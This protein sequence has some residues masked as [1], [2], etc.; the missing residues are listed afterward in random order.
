LLLKVVVVVAK[1][2]DVAGFGSLLADLSGELG[3]GL[4]LILQRVLVF[5]RMHRRGGRLEAVAK[6][7]NDL[8]LEIG[9]LTQQ[10]LLMSGRRER[11]VLA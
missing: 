3:S 1:G 8:R 9:N 5:V 4:V 7:D 6:V 11:G 10:P 2:P